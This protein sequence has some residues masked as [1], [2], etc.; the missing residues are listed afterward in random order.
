MKRLVQLASL[1]LLLVCSLPALAEDQITYTSQP[2]E[3]V[4]FLNDIAYVRDTLRVPGD[5]E[6]WITLPPQVYQDTLI[7]RQDDQRVPEYRIHHTEGETSLVIGATGSADLHAITLEYLTAGASWKPL[8]DMS[9]SEQETASV[10]LHFFAELQNHAFTLDGVDVKLIA[11]YVGTRGQVDTAS[12]LTMN[13]YIAGY[14]DDPSATL[15]QGAVTIQYIYPLAEPVSAEP[16][17]ALYTQLLSATLPARRLLLW[18]AQTDQQVTVIYKVENRSEVPLSEGI[19]RSY[20]DGLFVSSDPIEF[21]PIGSEG[22]VTVGGLRDVRVNSSRT[23]SYD[24]EQAY[25]R[26]TLHAITLTMRNFSES[27]VAIE[28]VDSYPPDSGEFEFSVQPEFELGN[29]LRWQ[30]T[31]PPDETVEI[32]YSYRAGS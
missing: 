17:D 13:Q 24:G 23:I 6:T 27:P 16:G 14:Q 18:N 12:T 19:V 9:F 30:V 10:D 5:A 4:V 2:D 29:L 1:F 22:S 11:G 7:V 26:D 3:L 15:A 21:T 31:L 25:D 32:E 28:V 8:Y 20:Q